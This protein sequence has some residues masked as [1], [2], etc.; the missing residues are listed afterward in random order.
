MASIGSI[1]ELSDLIARL[2]LAELGELRACREECSAHASEH[3]F[4]D[5]LQR[6]HVLTGFQVEKLARRETDGLVLGGAKL[7]YR[8]SAGSFAR[9]YR[10]SSLQDGTPVG[11]KV[12]RDR[13]AADPETVKLFHREG[14]IGRRLKH[15]NIV[16]IWAVGQEGVHHFITMEFVEGGNLRDF[17][18]IR[19]KLDPVETCRY[20]VNMADALEYALSQG[21]SHRD[22]KLTNVLMSSQGTAKLIDFGLAA[23]DHVLNRKDGP[24]LQQALEYSTLEKG[25]GGPRNDPRSDLFFLGAI[26]YEL[27]TGTPPYPRT[28]DREER[29]RFNRY[30]DVRPV[31]AIDPRLPHCVADVVDQLLHTNPQLRPQRA[32][33]VAADLRAALASLKPNAAVSTPGAKPADA[34]APPRILCVESR[35]R[36]QDILRD[37]LSKRGYRVLLLS[38]AERAIVRI[39]QQPPDCLVLMGQA[40][41]DVSDVFERA[42]ASDRSHSMAAVLVLSE[43]QGAEFNGQQRVRVVQQPISLRGLR[44]AIESLLTELGKP[45]PEA[46]DHDSD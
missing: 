35:P 15:P 13:W 41:D 14:D 5:L 17:L 45:L 8:I 22:L 32:G 19:G 25:C 21:M 28:K 12:L 29:K 23:D 44:E 43:K 42:V 40:V 33:D 1:D 10:G 3:E 34:A 37:Y 27:L 9:V 46:S 30:R 39:G 20:G 38:D 26:L 18:K 7:L 11:I 24:D 6:K 36:Q 4:L 2:Q 16:P 31:T